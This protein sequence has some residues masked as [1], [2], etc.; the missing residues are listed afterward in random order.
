VLDQRGLAFYRIHGGIASHLGKV[1]SWH[2]GVSGGK[3]IVT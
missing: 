1:K 3:R 2:Q